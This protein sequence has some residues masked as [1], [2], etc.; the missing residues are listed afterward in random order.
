[1]AWCATARRR[2]AAARRCGGR[3]AAPGPSDDHPRP[4]GGLPALRRPGLL[5]GR[6]GG[7]RHGLHPGRRRGR[8]DPRPGRLLARHRVG[9]GWRPRGEDHRR[10]RL[11][12]GRHQGLRGHQRDASARRGEPR[13]RPADPDLPLSDLPI[14]PAYGGHLRGAARALARL[15]ALGDRRDDQLAVELDH[16]GDGAGCRDRLRPPDRCE[17]PGG[18]APPA[19][20]PRRH[21]R[22][23]AVG[24]SRGGS[25]RRHRDSRA[26]SA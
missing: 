19:R 16:V 4:T 26:A 12:R 18:A 17:I 5:A 22:G 3:T 14:R 2:R 9:P 23:D 11:L 20:P 15:R 8:H 7:D 24:G 10:R 6:Q 13:D 1:M 21:G 25:V